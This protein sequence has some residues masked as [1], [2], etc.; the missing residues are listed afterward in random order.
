[1]TRYPLYRK[2]SEHHGRS[3]QVWK[4]SPAPEFEPRTVHLVATRYS[5][6]STP[7][8]DLNSVGVLFESQPEL[9]LFLT[10]VFMFFPFV[11]ARHLLGITW[12]TPRPLDFQ[13]LPII[14]QQS[15][16]H[17]RYIVWARLKDSYVK[18][19]PKNKDPLIRN[20]YKEIFCINT[21]LN[22]VLRSPAE[23]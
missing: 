1:M 5:D 8:H 10:I 21:V 23:I 14:S 13:S 4:I 6:Y 12:T 11:H 16:C 18:K 3:G 7:I 22:M 20:K 17:E 19:K 15:S 9:Q 2:L